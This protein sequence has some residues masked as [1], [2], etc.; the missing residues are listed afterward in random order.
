MKKALCFLIAVAI[1]SSCWLLPLAA[2]EAKTPADPRVTQLETALAQAVGTD[3]PGGAVVLFENGSVVMLEGFGYADLGERVLVNAETVFELGELTGLFTAITILKLADAGRLSLDTSIAAYLPADFLAELALERPVTLRELL[4]GTAGFEGRSFD[5]LFSKSTHMF[6]TLEEALLSDI[7][8]QTVGSEDVRQYAASAFSVSLAAYVAETALGIGFDQ[9]VAEELLT[10]LGM[11]STVLLPD[12]STVVNNAALGYTAQGD[13][14]FTAAQNGGRV[15]T[16]LPYATGALSTAADL[17]RLLECLLSSGGE[18]LSPAVLEALFAPTPTSALFETSTP[19]FSLTLGCYAICSR[20]LYFGATIALDRARGMG[21]LTLTNAPDSSLNEL[22]VTLCG[23]PVSG[24]YT[25]TG[26]GGELPELKTYRGL[27]A[28]ATGESHTFAGRYAMIDAGERASVDREEGTL[29]FLGLRLTQIAPGVFADVTDEGRAATV[30]FLLDADGNVV[31]VVTANGE[32]YVPLASYRTGQLAKLLFFALVILAGWFL[33]YGLFS[34]IRYLSG[35]GREHSVGF[36]QS[37][38]G[39]F[40]FFFSLF[41][42][43]QVLLCVNSSAGVLSSAYLVLSVLALIFG[44][45]AAVAFSL[46]I[47]TSLLNGKRLRHAARAAILFVV[48]VLLAAFWG[49]IVL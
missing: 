6:E 49:L 42:L 38:P 18:V 47:L 5:Y 41:V 26:D 27:Y 8:A 9:L 43:W 29:S 33:V 25:G 3:T 4:S 32:S 16:G 14:R 36:F 2:N 28:C 35:L 40:T 13:G 31:G 11:S 24:S 22:P 21:V 1:L 15:F 44:I 39:F 19:G 34:S 23:A 37:L 48:Y 30:Q 45:G 10:P 17:A 20:T 46:A 12:Q 7:P